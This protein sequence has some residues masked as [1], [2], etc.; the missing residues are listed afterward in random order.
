MSDVVV[1]GTVVHTS[2]AATRT[3]NGT[4]VAS[5][6]ARARVDRVFQGKAARGELQFTWFSP[7]WEESGGGVIYSGPP[8][9]A[10]TPGKR[11]LIFLR[12]MGSRLEVAMPLYE[13]E[14]ELAPRSPPAAATDLSL[15]PM[16]ERYESVAEELEAAALAQPPP[17]SG[18]TGMAAAIFP[19]VF[20]LVG[21]CA[22][23]LYRH[24]LSV[25]SPELRGAAMTWLK[26]VQ[27]RR[28]K[29]NEPVRLQKLQ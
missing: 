8:L 11:Y 6:T 12:R 20:D 26:L 13:L 19:W 17:S 24:F 2:R 14:V 10:F 7:R 18:T 15:L 22:E 28:L 21:G 27:S 5:N 1:S 29:C 3:I 23:P 25:P 4:E 16:K 9:A